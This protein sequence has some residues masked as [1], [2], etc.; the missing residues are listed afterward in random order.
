MKLIERREQEGRKG[1]KKV[2]VG[3]L[4]RPLWIRRPPTPI[5]G[6][7]CHSE[8]FMTWK[9]EGAPDN[10]NSISH[11]LAFLPLMFTV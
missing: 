10:Q 1:G 5:C 8:Q 9:S 3:G 6:G 11:L 7:K 4:L 2:K